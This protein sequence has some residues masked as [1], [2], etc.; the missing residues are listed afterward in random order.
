M[1]YYTR[2]EI[3]RAARFNDERRMCEALDAC[4]GSRDL[5]EAQDIIR[6]HAS[7]FMVQ[8]SGSGIR[9]GDIEIDSW[10][11]SCPR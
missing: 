10:G 7:P 6:E 8:N 3:E 9:F 2:T 1:D 4:F 5:D 11:H